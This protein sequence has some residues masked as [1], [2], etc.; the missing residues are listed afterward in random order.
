MDQLKTFLRNLKRHHFWVLCCLILILGSVG[1]YISV[2]KLATEED[3]RLRLISAGY[4]SVN[5]VRGVPDHPNAETT[6]SMTDLIARRKQEVQEAWKRMLDQQQKG[7]GQQA[8]FTWPDFSPE[9][10]A[11]VRQENGFLPFEN[12]AY[13]TDPATGEKTDPNDVIQKYLREAYRDYVKKELPKLAEII[14]AVWTPSLDGIRS[15]RS[16]NE[17]PRTY[18]PAT[19]DENGDSSIIVN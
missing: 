10:T 12:S 11:L 14:G 2:G 13:R 6:T 19:S 17:E 5:N 15:T 7:D 4:S 1:W 8:L 9:F 3:D 16:D 18:S